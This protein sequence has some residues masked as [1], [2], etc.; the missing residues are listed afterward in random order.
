M[1]IYSESGPYG[2]DAK[3]NGYINFRD[4]QK[5]ID[6]EVAKI[7]MYEIPEQKGL[8]DPSRRN[9]VDAR[10]D[11]P[12]GKLT[13]LSIQARFEK[14]EDEQLALQIIESIKFDRDSK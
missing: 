5:T 12:D 10:F 11:M 6:G 7:V 1:T 2:A 8:I 9:C 4:T 14:R 13:E 3:N